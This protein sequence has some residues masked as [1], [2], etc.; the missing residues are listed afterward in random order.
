MKVPK[1]PNNSLTEIIKEIVELCKQLAPEYGEDASWFLPPV[2]EEEISQWET[3]NKLVIPD[4]YKEW[5]AFSSESQVRNVLA[6]FYEPEKFRINSDGIP[7]DYVEIADLIGDGERLC[8]SK[9]TGKL[10]W[11]DHGKTEEMNNFKD[12]LKEII[13]MLKK[14][15]GLSKKSEELLLSMVKASK[16][17]HKAQEVKTND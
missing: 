10:I 8:F 7:D 14:E 17:R 15:S 13:R 12:V 11:F 16:E 9:T 6:H 1:I 3:E 2:S 4:S 5:L